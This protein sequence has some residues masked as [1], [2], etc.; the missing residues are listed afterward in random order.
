MRSL[1]SRGGRPDL[2]GPAVLAAVTQPTLLL[3]GGDDREVLR[4]NQEALARLGGVKRLTIVP[5]A[6]HLF[7]E[8]GALEQVADLA[9]AWFSEHLAARSV[10]P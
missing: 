6:T 4:L 5:G 7:E 3:V 1:R 9:V 10:T 2:A 8:P